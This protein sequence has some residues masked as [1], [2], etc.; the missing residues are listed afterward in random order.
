MINCDFTIWKCLYFFFINIFVKCRILFF[1]LPHTACRISVPL[2][3]TEAR[4]QQWKLSPNHW[5]T[6]EFQLWHSFSPFHH[7]LLASPIATEKFISHFFKGK[8]SHPPPFF[9]WSAFKI[10]LIVF[11]FLQFQYVADFHLFILL[12]MCMVCLNLW[13]N[14]SLHFW[15]ILR[16]YA[17][18]IWLLPILSSPLGLQWN[19]PQVF[20]LYSLRHLLSSV[21]SPPP[22]CLSF[23]SHSVCFLLIYLLIHQLS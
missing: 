5:T 2:R 19:T 7:C 23:R 10:F 18:Q 1:W 8:C 11:S 17:I 12:D 4:P 15:K 9:F 21:Y 14:D 3:G 20:S 6:T 16:Y 13:T 22:I